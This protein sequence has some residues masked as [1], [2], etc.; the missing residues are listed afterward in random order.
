MESKSGTNNLS[1]VTT[2]WLGSD[3]NPLPSGCV[4]KRSYHYSTAPQMVASCIQTPLLFHD[5]SGTPRRI[6]TDFSWH[7][8]IFQFQYL[9]GSAS[10]HRSRTLKWKSCSRH[11]N[12]SSWFVCTHLPRHDSS[13][14]AKNIQDINF[15]PSMPWTS[16]I[17]N[18]CR[19]M[20]ATLKPLQGR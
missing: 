3:L 17:I 8:N 6:D 2:Q 19:K 16:A 18:A 14:S 11:Q 7:A 10:L 15:R 1:K 13:C 9:T 4:G 5:N 20:L 12:G